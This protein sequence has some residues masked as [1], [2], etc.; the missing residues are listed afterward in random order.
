MVCGRYLLVFI[1]FC[2]KNSIF[3]IHEVWFFFVRFTR[4]AIVSFGVHVAIISRENWYCF[5]TKSLCIGNTVSLKDC[6][7]IVN[8]DNCFLKDA[9]K[10]E[11]ET[12]IL[13]VTIIG[14]YFKNE[15]SST[16]RTILI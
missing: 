12:K 4:F 5:T 13:G 9:K 3:Q 16:I 10:I 2:C 1:Y 6:G 7:F 15:T 11:N 14:L 8:Y